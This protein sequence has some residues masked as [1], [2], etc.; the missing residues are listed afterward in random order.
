MTDSSWLDSCCFTALL[1]ASL[2]LSSHDQQAEKC[3][4]GSLVI[5]GL[6]FLGLAALAPF[7]P[8]SFL[9]FFSPLPLPSLSPLPFGPLAAAAALASAILASASAYKQTGLSTNLLQA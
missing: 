3:T 5:C 2:L 1:C 9:A 7:S 8:P 6:A 4:V